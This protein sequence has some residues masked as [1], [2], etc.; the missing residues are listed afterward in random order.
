M[1]S[2]T[3]LDIVVESHGS[4]RNSS[5]H[6]NLLLSERTRQR[7]STV[8]MRQRLGWCIQHLAAIRRRAPVVNHHTTT[9]TE[10]QMVPRTLRCKV[11]SKSGENVKRL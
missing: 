4:G 5:Q 2:Q 10:C 6:R 7:E 9:S 3:D 1:G 8:V 11:T